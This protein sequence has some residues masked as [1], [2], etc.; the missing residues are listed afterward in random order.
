MG[1]DFQE[2]NFNFNTQNNSLNHLTLLISYSVKDKEPIAFTIQARN[3]KEVPAIKNAIKEVKLFN[4]D[5][6]LVVTKN[7]QLNT[8]NIIEFLSN[9]IKFLTLVDT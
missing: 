6:P 8:N 3:I 5:N 7:G 4:E 1:G 2:R 9:K